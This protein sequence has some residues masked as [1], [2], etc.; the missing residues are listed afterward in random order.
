MLTKYDNNKNIDFQNK[1]I[2][3]ISFL[4]LIASCRNNELKF[5][6]ATWNKR[7]DF[8]YEN[9]EKMVDDLI[10]NHLHKGMP[11]KELIELL[12]PSGNYSNLK[13]NSIGYEISV[14]YGH[15]IDPIRST[16][17]VFN[18]SKDS[19]VQDF[20]IEKWKHE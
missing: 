13:P 5:D 2:F 17:L 19:I 15:D 10:E 18:L 12:G 4:L 14:F 20:K 9:R 3:L 16:V 1:V 6:K 8:F 11:Y 7:I